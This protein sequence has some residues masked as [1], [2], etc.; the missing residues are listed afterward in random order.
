MANDSPPAAGDTAGSRPG[1]VAARVA[2]AIA[3][4]A[5]VAGVV[6]GLQRV[7]TYKSTPGKNAEAPVQWPGSHRIVPVAGRSTLVMFVHPLCSCTRASLAELDS[8]LQQT[9]GAVSAWVLV[10]RPEGTSGDWQNSSTLTAAQRLHGV[11]VLNDDDGA[12]AAK[13][14]AITSGQVVLYDAKGHLQFSGGIT[15]ARGHVGENTGETRVLNL[16]KSGTAD[17][18]DHAVFGCGLHDPNPRTDSVPVDGST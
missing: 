3:V 6:F 17:A 15:G 16:V 18:H 12:E 7:W 11:Q 1:R 13:F 4:L 10:L 9:G 2:V 8:I 5:W 14:G